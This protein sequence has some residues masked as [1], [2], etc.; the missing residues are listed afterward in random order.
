MYSPEM[1]YSPQ[2][3]MKLFSGLPP[4]FKGKGGSSKGKGGRSRGKG[5][6]DRKGGLSDI[7]AQIA[8]Q[9]AAAIEQPVYF[10]EE[11]LRFEQQ[12]AEY[13]MM[14]SIQAAQ[15]QAALMRGNDSAPQGYQ[16][17]KGNGSMGKG[18][19][20]KSRIDHM[21]RGAQTAAARN[22]RS[23]NSGAQYPGTDE[24]VD[25]GPEDFL[26]NWVDSHGNSVLVYSADA[27]EVVLTATIS[28][29]N[30]NDI[31]LRVRLNEDASW[32]CGNSWLDCSQSSPEQICWVAADQRRSVWTR[33]R[34]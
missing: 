1:Q 2:G 31:T 8:A 33:G 26:G 4:D 11:Q 23:R 28:R 5:S 24:P 19:D 10:F 30:K 16:K 7:E 9:A 15:D 20:E 18:Q 6:Y 32:T 34:K 14:Q 27:W 13:K 22:I 17:K 29:P 25:F 3:G 12:Q 21:I